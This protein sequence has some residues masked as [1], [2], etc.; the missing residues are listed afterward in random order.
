MSNVVYLV[1]VNKLTTL[2]TP[3]VNTFVKTATGQEFTIRRKCN[4]V[5]GLFV[6]KKGL[7]LIIINKII[8]IYLSTMKIE[9]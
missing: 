6:S 8:Y 3:D 5:D 4:T 1:A 9:G 7:E 2:S